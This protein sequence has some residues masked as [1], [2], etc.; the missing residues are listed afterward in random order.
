MAAVYARAGG[1]S[2]AVVRCLARSQVQ[3]SAPILAHISRGLAIQARDPA[4]SYSPSAWSISVAGQVCHVAMAAAAYARAGGR[5]A[6]VVRCLARSPVHPRQF[7]RIFQ[8]AWRFRLTIPR[9][10]MPLRRYS[11]F[12]GPWSTLW[13]VTCRRDAD[14][15]TRPTWPPPQASRHDDPPLTQKRRHSAFTLSCDGHPAVYLRALLIASSLA[16]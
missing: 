14:T 6:A 15:H 1:R 16:R 11:G 13:Q 8:W 2:P 4:S 12:T 7:W 9:L 5:S 10:H 3:P